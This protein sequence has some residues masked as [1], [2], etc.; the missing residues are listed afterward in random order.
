LR[1]AILPDLK[2]E[3][4]EKRRRSCSIMRTDSFN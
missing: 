2:S 1:G 3:N 4:G